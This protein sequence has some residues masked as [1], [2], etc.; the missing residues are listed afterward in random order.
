M[1]L[2]ALLTNSGGKRGVLTPVR[3]LLM[4]QD[5]SRSFYHSLLDLRGGNLSQL[6][7]I[8]IVLSVFFVDVFIVA[9]C[10]CYGYRFKHSGAAIPAL[11]GQHCLVRRCVR[12]LLPGRNVYLGLEHRRTRAQF[13]GRRGRGDASGG[14]RV[15]QPR[16]AKRGRVSFSAYSMLVLLLHLCLVSFQFLLCWLACPLR[17]VFFSF[18]FSV[19]R[20]PYGPAAGF[21]GRASTDSVL[22][23][24]QIGALGG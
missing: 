5:T 12:G 7:A 8:A 14:P 18:K 3:V 22:H 1:C 17:M 23:Q 21:E 24:A 9:L 4:L 16:Y 10:P 11:H 6:L 15:H 20:Q 19:I 13:G 2:R